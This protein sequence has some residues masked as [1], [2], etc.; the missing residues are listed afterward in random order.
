MANQASRSLETYLETL[1]TLIREIKSRTISEDQ[2][3]RF[4]RQLR[5]L[6][7]IWQRGMC[8]GPP[9]CSLPSDLLSSMPLRSGSQDVKLTN[10]KSSCPNIS[11]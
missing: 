5:D 4:T 11:P 1:D 2:R 3:K 8:A 9:S 6:L 10:L 7:A